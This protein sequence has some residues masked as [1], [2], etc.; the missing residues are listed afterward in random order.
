LEKIGPGKMGSEVSFPSEIVLNADQVAHV[1]PQTSGIVRK[2]LKHLGD[3]VRAGDVMAWIESSELGEAKVDYFSKL[4]EVYC[5]RIDLPR[6]K[7]IHDNTIQMLKALDQMPTLDELKRLNNMEMGENRSRL[8]SVYAELVFSR[9]AYL[10]EKGLYAKKISSEED[11]QA[12]EKGYKK[13]EAEYLAIR[14]SISFEVKKNLSEIERGKRVAEFEA[15]AAKQKLIMLG[16]T[17]KDVNTLS[18]LPPIGVP[19]KKSVDRHSDQEKHDSKNRSLALYPLRAPFKG[20]VIKKH[21]TLGEKIGDDSD[22]F[23]IANLSSVW[24]NVNVSQKD[25]CHVKKGQKVRVAA[26]YGIPDAQGVISYVAP[27]IEERTR[28]IVARVLLPN[29][30]GAWRPGLF[31]TAHI[32]ARGDA[33][34]LR[35]SRSAIQTIEG[36]SV[37]FIPEDGEFE[38][39]PVVIGR[40][41]SKFAE[42][43]SG[44]SKGQLYVSRGGFE[45][46]AKIITSSLDAHAG[47]GH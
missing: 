42:I 30:K 35:I 44:L 1:V 28:A 24:V 26:G 31:V 46:K 7:A 23:T 3:E 38:A 4:N 11:F 9:K 40:S 18:P 47:H 13:A 43:L 10:R 33:A 2:V 25:L 22:V 5:S 12:S 20:T 27:I 21:I 8:I 36:K 29:P 34:A 6:A 37:V 41:N 45:L 17:V 15:E 39:V 19:V 16:L 14:D 32:I